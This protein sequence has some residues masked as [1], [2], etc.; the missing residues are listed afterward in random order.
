MAPEGSAGA[1]LG[2]RSHRRWRAPI[3]LALVFLW[4]G[5]ARA[6]GAA[7][8][9]GCA[10]SGA[11]TESCAYAGRPLVEVLGELRALGLNL[12]FSSNLVRPDMVVAAEPPVTTTRRL[13]DHLLAP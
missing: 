3:A 2:C 1:D 13:L 10:R 4:D 6:G 9:Q 7:P 8:T 11:G 5:S 12:I